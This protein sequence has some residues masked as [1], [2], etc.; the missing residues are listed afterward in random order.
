MYYDRL[1]ADDDDDDNN[2]NNNNIKAWIFIVMQIDL[3]Y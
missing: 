1:I 2:N 3:F